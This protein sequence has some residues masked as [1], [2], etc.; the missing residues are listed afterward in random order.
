MS[1]FLSF[2]YVGDYTKVGLHSGRIIILDYNHKTSSFVKSHQ[3]TYGK[4]EAR[5][6]VAGQ[7]L[8]TDPKDIVGLDVGF[9]N[10]MFAALERSIIQSLIQILWG[11]IQQCL[12]STYTYHIV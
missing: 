9:E 6:F 2:Y 5:R 3:E 1:H 4:S 7:Y 8:A 12:G 10:T 11:G